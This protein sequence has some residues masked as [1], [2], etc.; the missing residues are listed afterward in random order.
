MWPFAA[1]VVCLF[2]HV[3]IMVITSVGPS[4]VYTLTQNLLITPG[5][6][7]RIGSYTRLCWSHSDNNIGLLTL[8]AVYRRWDRLY[9]HHPPPAKR[10]EKCV[11]GVS[12]SASVCHARMRL[13]SIIKTH[14]SKVWRQSYTV[15]GYTV[16]EYKVIES[17]FAV[18]IAMY[19]C[20]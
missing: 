3:R 20:V 6:H 19:A 18:D 5:V 9:L 4:C 17:G 16:V 15:S 13:N 12:R 10:D 2:L 14:A 7:V 1:C 11:D 8:A